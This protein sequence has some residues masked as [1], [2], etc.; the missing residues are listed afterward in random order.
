MHHFNPWTLVRNGLNYE[1]G[2]GSDVPVAL[3]IF[4]QGLLLTLGYVVQPSTPLKQLS[5]V[6]LV[7]SIEAQTILR[8]L[9]RATRGSISIM[10]LG[11]LVFVLSGIPLFTFLALRGDPQ[12]PLFKQVMLPC[13]FAAM[14]FVSSHHQGHRARIHVHL[15]Q[16][17]SCISYDIAL[18]MIMTD[19][20]KRIFSNAMQTMFLLG[21]YILGYI[22]PHEAARTTLLAI[23]TAFGS[24]PGLMQISPGT[25]GVVRRSPPP[26]SALESAPDGPQTSW[27]RSDI[28][29][30]FGAVGGSV[31]GP[32]LGAVLG[33]ALLKAAPPRLRRWARKTWLAWRSRGQ[34]TVSEEPAIN[35]VET[36][37]HSFEEASAMERGLV[38]DEDTERAYADALSAPVCNSTDSF[39][40]ALEEQS[41]EM[42]EVEPNESVGIEEEPLAMP[43]SLPMVHLPP[44]H[45]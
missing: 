10:L 20:D 16:V 15:G 13:I 25:H 38:R 42:Q 27:S 28:I 1:Q 24:Y 37:E 4:A 18:W 21:L 31:F 22:L 30:I 9:E 23:A 5:L 35:Q 44:P 41:E 39:H 26:G 36:T 34:E 33:Y 19:V 6:F 43:R 29:A 7:I 32:I 17:V 2:G 40:T 14:G 45:D 12:I 11:P 8:V 3:K